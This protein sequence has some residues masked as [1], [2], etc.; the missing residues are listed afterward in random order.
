MSFSEPKNQ[1]VVLASGGGG[2][3]AAVVKAQEKFGYRVSMLVVDQQ[4]GAIEIARQ[5]GI[6]FMLIHKMPGSRHFATRLQ[7]ILPDETALLVLAGF[8]S[9]LSAEF[10]TSWHRRIINTHPSLLP[11]YGGPGMIGV[12]V[13]EAVMLAG[14]KDTGCTIHYVD[15]GVDS[16]ATIMQSTIAVDYQ[17]TPWQLG[18]RVHL[19][20]NRLLP[21][22]IAVVLKSLNKDEAV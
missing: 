17:Q 13:Q 14:E 7:Q 20:E 11:K 18:G 5:H 12:K 6:P 22:A 21:E 2:N 15:A 19:E 1:I 16:G 9:I 10:C 3:F 4:C 8:T